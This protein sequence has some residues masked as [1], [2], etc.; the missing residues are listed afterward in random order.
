MAL[1][2]LIINIAFLVL[3]LLVGMF[4]WDELPKSPRILLVILI[5]ANMVS[6]TSIMYVM[7]NYVPR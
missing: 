4:A 1:L 7:T 6:T 5:F 2:A 3:W